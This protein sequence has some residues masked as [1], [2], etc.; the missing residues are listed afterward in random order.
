MAKLIIHRKQSFG[1]KLPIPY[2]IKINGR[3]ICATR[4]DDIQIQLPSASYNIVICYVFPFMR[5]N[6]T[7]S[8]TKY[9]VIHDDEIA[10]YEFYNREYIW[11]LLFDI[12]LLLW[13]A[14]L[15]FNLPHPWNITYKVLSNG[16]FIA[17]IIRL[18]LIRDKYFVIKRKEA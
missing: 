18:W 8:S 11:D 9:I 6:F 4:L 10:E 2:Y 15:F 16:F 7:L 14:E 3:I 5:W 13:I 1:I 12:D 17:W